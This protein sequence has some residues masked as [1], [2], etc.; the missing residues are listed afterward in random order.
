M[1]KKIRIVGIPR[2]YL[3]IAYIRK[4]INKALINKR[5]IVAPKARKF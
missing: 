2:K 3:S 1:P 5:L 4:E